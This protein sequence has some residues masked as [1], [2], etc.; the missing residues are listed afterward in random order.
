[1]LSYRNFIVTAAI[2]LAAIGGPLSAPADVDISGTLEIIVED[3]PELG[4]ASTSYFLADGDG[5]RYRVEFGISPPAGLLTGSSV[6]L[7]GTVGKRTIHVGPE[8]P[9]VVHE[10]AA[11]MKVGSNPRSSVLLL[12]D[13]QDAAVTCSEATVAAT[14]F[15]GGFS[16]DG[17]YQ[18][19]SFGAVSFPR[20]TDGDG[21]PDVFRVTIDAQIADACSPDAW[22]ADADGAALGSGIDL[23]SYQHKVYVLPQTGCSWAGRANVGCGSSCRVWVNVCGIPDLYAHELG[24][25]LSLRHS[26][27][28]ADNDDVSESTYG[29]ISDFMG[30]GGYGWRQVNG[31]HKLEMGWIPAGQVIDGDQ[32][33]TRNYVLSPLETDPASA[34]YPQLVK[35]SRPSLGDDLFLSYRRKIGYDTGLRSEYA[36]K[37]NVHSHDGPGTNTLCIQMLDDGQQFEDA[38]IGLEVFQ[39]AHDDL[40]V[41]LQV[42]LPANCAGADADADGVCDVD[43]I[44]PGGDD[45]IDSDLDGTPD[46]CDPCPNGDDTIDNDGDGLCD[47]DDPDDDNDGEADF[48]DCAPFSRGVSSIAGPIGDTLRID[49]TAE[50]TLRWNQTDARSRCCCGTQPQRTTLGPS[51]RPMP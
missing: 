20:D 38:S 10:D 26:S 50:T 27:N 30:Y 44:C 18:D 35:I 22:A 42:T 2:T 43:D 19:T 15:D 21:Q 24:H 7:R 17:L 6:T 4:R 25:N 11:T 37:T 33:G 28:D 48:S 29:D 1:M 36:D 13:F 46:Y 3:Q 8:N 47:A 23:S 16:V 12:V 40:S 41:T 32:G 45:T 49:K 34:P 14:M 5:T 31:P 39:V 9:V 51:M